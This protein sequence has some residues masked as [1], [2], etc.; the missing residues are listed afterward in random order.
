[1]KWIGTGILTLLTLASWSAPYLMRRDLLFGVTV[2]PE[3]RDTPAARSMVRLYQMRV[4]LCGLAVVMLGLL[5]PNNEHLGPR[6]VIPPL[7]F[8]VGSSI[9]FAQSHRASRAHTVPAS[10]VREVELLPPARASAEYPPMLLA[11]PA[12]L[13]AGFASAFLIPDP[14]GQIPLFA[15]G[16][17][18]IARWNAI[19]ALVDKPFSFALGA[20]IGSFVALVAFRFGTR[21]S[22]SGMTNYRRVMLRNIIL[23]NAAFAAFAVWVVNM[24]AFG[25]MVDRIELRVGMAAIFAGLAAHLAYVLM[26][27]RKENMAL[28][29]VVGH[30][31][32][33][34]TPDASWLWGMFYHNPDDPALF[35]EARTGPGYTVN[36]G[37]LRAWLMVAGF[38]FLLVLPF[39]LK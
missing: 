37:H 39:L 3:F 9:A 21:R 31:L 14:T 28:V 24:G 2:P 19:D 6:W 12:I 23:F 27:R 20:C 16:G 25:R 1:M 15:G 32:G 38:L 10:G 18:I 8:F 13:A 33:D 4:L 36:F 17:A 35:V 29:S 7:L 26:L 11:G 30:S 22:P 34:R 5:M